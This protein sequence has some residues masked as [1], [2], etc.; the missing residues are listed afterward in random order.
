MRRL[1]LS[2]AL[3]CLGEAQLSPWPQTWALNKSTIIM[4]CNS[5][6]DLDPAATGFAAIVDVD[7]SSG[8]AEWA[9]G[10]PMQAD[11]TPRGSGAC[12][13][14]IAALRSRRGRRVVVVVVSDPPSCLYDV[15]T[16]FSGLCGVR[17]RLQVRPPGAGV[18]FTGVGCPLCCYVAAELELEPRRANLLG[19]FDDAADG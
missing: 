15:E 8:K 14:R 19:A 10:R 12:L 7:W 1:A 6:G 3:L 4:A 13:G 18:K 5:S 11:E 2:A 16:A 9:K 17:D